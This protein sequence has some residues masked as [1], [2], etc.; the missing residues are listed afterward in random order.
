MSAIKQEITLARLDNALLVDAKVPALSVNFYEME[1]LLSDHIAQY[2]IT[3]TGET[4][5][6]SKALAT[7]LNKLAGN[8]DEKRKEVVKLVSAPIKDFDN[9]MKLLAGI[10]QE[11]RQRI[12]DQVKV[13]EDETRAQVQSLLSAHRAA[14]WEEMGIETIFRRAQIDDLIKLSALTKKGNLTAEAQR[15]IERRVNLDA[16]RMLLVKERL[17]RLEKIC[18][19]AG[20]DSPISAAHLS[21]VIELD[22]K[23]YRAELDR[24][25]KAEL[26]R[27]RQAEQRAR[28]REQAR[29]DILAPRQ[30][31]R[32]GPVPPASPAPAEEVS[33]EV[34]E[35]R[36]ESG[37][38]R[39]EVTATFYPQ[40]PPTVS[41][42]QLDRE[43][44][45][46]LE[47]AGVKTLGTL[48]MRPA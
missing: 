27:Q 31:G 34:A 42:E 4:L 43:F 23:V 35:T 3:V 11:G 48:T 17:S 25:L 44:R 21:H 6:D 24:L 47:K 26:E 36:T 20:L 10:C 22:D 32:E 5:K 29:A 13:F 39:W 14:Y 19:D 15:E 37:K 33:E 38:V 45:R 8:I 30:G 1:V 2:D 46:V 7:E 9:Q 41:A 40:V 16:D 28:A 18:L 12:T